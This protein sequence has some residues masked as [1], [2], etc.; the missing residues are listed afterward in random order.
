MRHHQKVRLTTS[1]D[2]PL[3][4]RRSMGVGESRLKVFERE[5]GQLI[6]KATR[7]IGEVII[8]ITY[9]SETDRA[10]SVEM[11]DGELN[12]VRLMVR[13]LTRAFDQGEEQP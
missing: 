3:S 5:E 4:I 6:V 10:K 1:M 11:N 13:D 9:I 7:D 8:K 2:L 12:K